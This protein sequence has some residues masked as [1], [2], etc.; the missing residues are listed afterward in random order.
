MLNAYTGQLIDILLCVSYVTIETLMDF[1]LVVAGL[2]FQSN[3]D[4]N[5]YCKMNSVI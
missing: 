5:S 4:N 2:V 3:H 1:V